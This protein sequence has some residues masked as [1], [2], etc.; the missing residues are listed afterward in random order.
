MALDLASGTEP[1]SSDMRGEAL[2]RTFLL[3]LLVI[4]LAS[5]VP[6]LILGAV[7]FISYDGYWHLFIARHNNWSM[8]WA[9]VKAD[10]HPPLY[11]LIQY[12]ISL[13]G[14]SH[15]ISRSASILPGV[16][17]T[18]VIGLIAAKLFRHRAVALLTALSYG[19]A[20]TIIDLTI[21]VRAYPLA[22][23]FCLL[24]YYAFL[25]IIHDPA[26]EGHSRRLFGFALFVSLAILNEYYSLLFFASC[27]AVLVFYALRDSR[28][29]VLVA[30]SLV[31][32]RAAWA[33]A[34]GVPL[35]VTAVMYRLQMRFMPG[36]Q[37]HLREFYWA[38]HSGI[39][40]SDF[41][42]KNLATE[43]GYFFP[44]SVLTL[45]GLAVLLLLT[46]PVL[47]N[48]LMLRHDAATESLRGSPALILIFLLLELMFASATG[49]YP[50]GGLLRQQSIIAPFFTLTG[51]LFLDW[52]LDA[53]RW[54]WQRLSLLAAVALCIAVTFVHSWRSY[55]V[56]PEELSSA[57]YSN[58][59][60]AF[61]PP[62]IY[63]DF[64]STFLYF[65][66]TQ[67]SDW[68]F[69]RLVRQGSRQILTYR[70]T[71][72][73]GQHR[74]FMRCRDD[75]NFNLSDPTFY[76][77][78]ASD[79]STARL[80]SVVL[81]HLKQDGQPLDAAVC[82]ADEAKFKALALGAGLDYGRAVYDGLQAYV[83]FHV[84]PFG[85][86]PSIGVGAGSL[87]EH[88]GD[89]WYL[90]E[91]GIRWMG[92]RAVV[93]ELG[94]V[95]GPAELLVDTYWPSAL[96]ADGPVHVFAEAGGI[97]LKPIEVSG[98][99]GARD[100]RWRLPKTL[101]GRKS[102]DV[103]LKVDKARQYDK[104]PRTLGMAVSRIALEAPDGAR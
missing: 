78:L 84:R 12:F 11:Y 32:W 31:R 80:D 64:Y 50:F 35:L 45:A 27:L 73:A 94:P 47:V 23:F 13:L 38:P 46:L 87:P 58:F 26:G 53:A 60:S 69:E 75:W 56:T 33:V 48:R 59:Q 17:A 91:Q 83:E 67:D 77:N 98:K 34:I 40:L 18:F 9:E 85:P 74:E 22:I 92:Q 62:V 29:R 4:T 79:L 54:S 81:F 39:T 43:L 49:H 100:L 66:H 2:S 24:A 1:V 95:P 96:L 90:A 86:V 30:A 72:S 21:D 28:Y 61:T 7:Q 57:Q 63:S 89:G 41:L 16:G 101:A 25:E 65:L 55:I 88:V 104:D 14:R 8:W 93:R 52:V 36:P 42:F 103:V 15:L 68:H 19:F 76:A 82:R 37:L 71:S 99:D 44:A 3:L 10:G 20:M 102:I 51:F 70:V 97:A 5:A 6:R